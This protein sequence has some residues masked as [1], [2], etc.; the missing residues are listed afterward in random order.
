MNEIIKCMKSPDAFQLNVFL[1]GFKV[2]IATLLGAC[3]NNLTNGLF[4]RRVPPLQHRVRGEV[5]WYGVGLEILNGRAE[6]LWCILL[7]SDYIPP[8][9]VCPN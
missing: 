2:A 3:V 5:V 9:I 6:E 8:P 4:L 1:H 7:S